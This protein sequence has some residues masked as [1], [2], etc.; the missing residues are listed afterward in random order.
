MDSP[1]LLSLSCDLRLSSHADLE[2]PIHALRNQ[3]P[4][5]PLH[6]SSLTVCCDEEDDSDF[7]AASFCAAA[8]THATLSHLR[9]EGLSLNVVALDA[10]VDLAISRQLS[11]LLFTQVSDMPA[12]LPSLTRLLA[13]G[14]LT[15][16]AIS[17]RFGVDDAELFADE[18]E[19]AAFCLALRSAKLR[20][21]S[22]DRVGVGSMLTL[23]LAVLRACVGHPTLKWLSI[24]DNPTDEEDESASIAV[25][26]LFALLVDSGIELLSASGS[27]MH[28]IGM[29]PLFAAVARSTRLHT[30]HFGHPSIGAACARDHILPAVR[31]NQ[32]LR[33]LHLEQFGGKS[34]PHELLQAEGLVIARRGA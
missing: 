20:K 16:L 6:I 1:N 31:A 30:L 21:L 27:R 5:G 28:D 7:D 13:D 32:S 29:H 34:T 15:E 11:R 26:H 4:F 8:S 23:Y 12:S 22:L 9:T 33:Y 10:I 3:P 19:T 2:S 25:G 17:Y 18:G 14:S 24:R